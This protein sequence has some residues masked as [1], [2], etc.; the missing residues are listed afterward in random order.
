M[1]FIEQHP[2]YTAY[3][4]EEYDM[5]DL[6]FTIRSGELNA[7]V[8]GCLSTCSEDDEIE[9]NTY[10]LQHALAAEL[11]ASPCEYAY[12]DYM[13]EE[14][15][16]ILNNSRRQDFASFMDGLRVIIEVTEDIERVN[17]FL[18]FHSIGY[19]AEW[20]FGT[21]C[22]NELDGTENQIETLE[23]ALETIP[24]DFQN[25]KAHI[26]QAKIQLREAQNDRSRKDALRDVLSAVEAYV[27]YISGETRIYNSIR[28]LADRIDAPDDSF[29][30]EGAEFWNKIH[31]LHPDIRHGN[32]A[33]SE[34]DL[35]EALYYIERLMCYLKYVHRKLN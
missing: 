12:Y 26:R 2:N 20:E 25:T 29:I 33:V 4:H 19:M 7:L 8:H 35:P 31:Q 1:K 32:E 10:R 15:I 22:W 3:T 14:I 34:L 27:N 21:I 6:P 28:A 5:C 23:E 30:R 17:Q 13:K 11:Q 24:D 16:R 18:E 9:G